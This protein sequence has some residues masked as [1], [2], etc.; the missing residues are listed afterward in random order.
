MPIPKPSKGESQQDF[1]SRCMGNDVMNSEYPDNKQRA[2]V[3]HSQ[4]D[5]P[6]KTRMVGGAIHGRKKK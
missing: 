3:C 1:I 4:W 2:G 6:K 5:R